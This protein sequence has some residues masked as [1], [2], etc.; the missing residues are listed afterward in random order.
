MTENAPPRIR[1]GLV[2]A[3][4]LVTW[5]SLGLSLFLNALLA[6][7]L[8]PTTVATQQYFAGFTR[9]DWIILS[10]LSL[11]HLTAVT[12]LW[13][14]RRVALWWFMVSTFLGT[15]NSGRFLVT[16]GLLNLYATLGPLGAVLSFVL[17]Y[18]LGL[19][20]SA[21]VLAYVVT[22]YRRGALG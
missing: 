8:F 10:L 15:L 20:V 21:A 17:S 22:L 12:L 9:W 18:A 7:G 6:L 1:P 2:T 19:A 5:L 13:L 11:I 4:A 16:H 3:I 14:L